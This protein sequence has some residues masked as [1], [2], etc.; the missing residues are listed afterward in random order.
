MPFLLQ[1][2]AVCCILF[3]IAAVL[4][5]RVFKRAATRSTKDKRTAQRKTKP[6]PR[7]DLAAGI[8]ASSQAVHN[9]P[10]RQGVQPP[11]KLEASARSKAADADLPRRPDWAYYNQDNGDLSDP[12][13]GGTPAGGV[14]RPT[15]S[16]SR[17]ER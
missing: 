15:G 4:W 14:Q 6:H 12:E 3:A 7:L 8:V 17:P 10:R 2:G 1:L 13:P 11:Q 9:A 16:L 5:W